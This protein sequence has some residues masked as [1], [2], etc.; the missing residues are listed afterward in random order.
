[1]LSTAGFTK[2]RPKLTSTTRNVLILAAVALAMAAGAVGCNLA[3][4]RAPE[5][6]AAVKED[7]RVTQEWISE[8]EAQAEGP[9]NRAEFCDMMLETAGD[10][11]WQ[12]QVAFEEAATEAMHEV[13]GD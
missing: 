12:E 1:M 4:S 3:L 5:L 11:L 9:T 13:Y 8:L 10:I 2:S 7:T 6:A